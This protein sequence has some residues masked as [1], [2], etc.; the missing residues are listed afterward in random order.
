MSKRRL[1][2]DLEE[3]QTG[4]WTE[5]KRSSSEYFIKSEPALNEDISTE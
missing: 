4:V 3:G 5:K 1:R 2:R